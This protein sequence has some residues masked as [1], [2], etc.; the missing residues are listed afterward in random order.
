MLTEHAISHALELVGVLDQRMVD[1]EP[2][3]RQGLFTFIVALLAVDT[4]V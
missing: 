4:E 3:L 2:V 1:G